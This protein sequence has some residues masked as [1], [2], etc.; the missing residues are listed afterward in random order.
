MVDSEWKRL[1]WL[2]VRAYHI[3]LGATGVGI[4]IWLTAQLE[5]WPA[6]RYAQLIAIAAIYLVSSFFLIP[7]GRA[8][9]NIGYPVLFA[10]LVNFG[11]VMGMWIIW[12]VFMIRWARQEID[13]EKAFFNIGQISICVLLAHLILTYLGGD[14]QQLTLLDSL[15]PLLAATLLFDMLNIL[16]VSCSVAL[17]SA[18]NGLLSQFRLFYWDYR[19]ES[20]PF[21]HSLAIVSSVLLFHEGVIALVLLTGTFL[22]MHSL[23]RLP[24]EVKKHRD[25]AM[26][27]G[28]TGALNYRFFD[29][30][31]EGEGAQLVAENTCFSMLMVDID[32]LKAIN[33]TY[34][35]PAGDEVIRQVAGCLQNCCRRNDYVIRYGGDEFLVILPETDPQG[36]KQVSRR[37][38]RALQTADEGQ[39]EKAVSFTTSGGVGAFP[40]HADTV[41]DL[42]SL[43]DKASYR[44]KSIDDNTVFVA[45]EETELKPE[46]DGITDQTEVV[47]L[48]TGKEQDEAQKSSKSG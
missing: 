47:N 16:L 7:L 2:W 9:L 41:E 11:P 4:T 34:G 19:R 24:Q 17:E 45:Q 5:G 36:A 39:E 13:A 27:D 26:R 37:W 44:G 48:R 18:D 28:M 31:C 15:G 23:L 42:F 8:N 29:Q 40:A 20:L 25:A 32:Q 12:P 43:V 10:T 35:H 3:G 14:P 1:S 38:L 22:G 6:E 30:W 21:Y 33:D 46:M